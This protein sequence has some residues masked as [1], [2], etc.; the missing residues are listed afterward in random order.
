MINENNTGQSTLLNDAKDSMALLQAVIDSLSDAVSVVDEKGKGIMIN[1]AYTRITGMTKEQVLNKPATVDIAEGESVHL[2]V[3]ETGKAIKGV[4]MKVGPLRREVIVSCAPIFLNK[5]LKGSVGVIHDISELRLVMEELERTRRL[6]RKLESRYTFKDIIGDSLPLRK[7]IDRARQAASTPISILLRGECGTGKEL[8]A[9][10]IHHDSDRA[11]EPFIRV[12]CASLTDTL[13]ESEL[14]G[15]GDGAFTGAKKG[16]R[17]GYF[18][19][20]TGGTLFLDEVGAMGPEAQARLLRALQEGEIIRVGESRSRQ[21]DVRI[22]AATNADLEKLVE[23]AHFRQDL[24]YRLN[25]F[26][27]Y[28][29][30]LKEMI[31][32]IPLLAN[33]FAARYALEYGR[34]SVEIAPAVFR[35]LKAYHWPGNIRELQNVVARA[36]INLDRQE[37]IITETHL[38]MPTLI[39]EAADSSRTETLAGSLKDLHQDWEKDILRKAIR[40]AGGNKAEAARILDISIRNLYNK[41][42]QHKLI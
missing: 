30:L 34:N 28:L 17:K 29:P 18:E 26:P 39:A 40:E 7:T 23:K 3:L 25:V 6:V 27:I 42:H 1:R 10:A 13:L 38:T 22:I 41:L 32:D 2:K 8:F 14:F 24:Y 19:E 36:V 16:G 12:N 35:R 15:Y 4:R 9:H 31:S 21:I 20:A 5:L 37:N 33:Y 11:D